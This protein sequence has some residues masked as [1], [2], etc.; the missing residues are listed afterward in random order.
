[1]Q[2]GACR[3]IAVVTTY[4]RPQ[5]LARLLRSLEQHC[6]AEVSGVV[7]VDNANDP[8]TAGVAR[9]CPRLL[10]YLPQSANRGHGAGH[11]V[12]LARAL[13]EPWATHFL[14]LDDDAIMTAGAVSAM[15]VQLRE[16]DGVAVPLIEDAAGRLRWF[17]GPLDRARWRVIRVPGITPAAF[18]A[19]CGP[20]PARFVWAPWGIMLLS[21]RVVE[22]VGLPR[23]DFGY[24]S[25]DIEYALRIT[26]RFPGWLVPAAV[27]RHFPPVDKQGPEAYF[28]HC[29]NLQ[30]LVYV[31]MRLPHGRR[32]WRHLPG[33]LL[34]LFRMR[35]W[36]WQTWSDA[37]CAVWWGWRRGPAGLP[38][39]DHFRRRWNEAR[40]T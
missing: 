5:V 9:D 16:Q 32:I 29:L 8:E 22:T 20:A 14:L 21:R 12:G 34:R 7:V 26:A 31:A 35:G 38:G 18:L 15:A 36:G 28:I 10:A 24:S 6:A 30:N 3:S 2:T 23:T 39:N 19:R 25:D 13:Q 1:M 33:H 11:A 27:A 37:A 4:R 17:P 40:A